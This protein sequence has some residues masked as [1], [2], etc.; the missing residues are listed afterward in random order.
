M[1]VAR[2]IWTILNTRY[3]ARRPVTHED[4]S[5]TPGGATVTIPKMEDLPLIIEQ[6]ARLLDV[7][8]A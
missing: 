1:N 3:V 8:A 6:A 4:G 5:T 7:L 2:K